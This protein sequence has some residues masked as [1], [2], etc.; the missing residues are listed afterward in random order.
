M[1]FLK[2]NQTLFLCLLF[3]TFVMGG[4][5]SK[6][7]AASMSDVEANKPAWADEPPGLD[8]IWGIGIANDP[9]GAV[10]MIAAEKRARSSIRLQ[11]DSI[12]QAVFVDYNKNAETPADDAAAI[13]ASNQIDRLPLKEAQ[14]LLRWHAPDGTWWYRLEYQK[15]DAKDT[16]SAILE[17]EASLQEDLDILLIDELLNSYIAT[18]STPVQIDQ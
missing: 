17:S 4:C 15:I 9:N 2:K 8:I 10:A 18:V 6:P 12:A 5:I 3:V 1:P 16:L 13:D 7:A 14:T 11:L